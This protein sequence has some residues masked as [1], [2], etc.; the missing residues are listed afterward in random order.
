[1]I[2]GSFEA[3]THFSELI[4]DV[5]KG[6]DIT[7]T[8]RGKPVAIIKPYRNEI[9][10]RKDIIAK[11]TQYKTTSGEDLRIKELINEGRR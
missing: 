5:Q 9:I 6:I 7:I 4:E 2:I 3:K 10:N 1:M 11:I 8:N